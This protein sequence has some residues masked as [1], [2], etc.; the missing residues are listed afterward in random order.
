MGLF[1]RKSKEKYRSVRFAYSAGLPGYVEGEVVS[2]TINTDAGMLVIKPLVC[3]NHPEINLPLSRITEV[4]EITEEEIKEKNKSVLGRAAVG[5]LLG[6]AGAIVGGLSGVGSKKKTENKYFVVIKYTD[7]VDDT[8]IVLEVV[9]AS[10]G[11][12]KFVQELSPKTKSETP[13]GPITL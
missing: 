12:G 9:G 2:A 4:T 1:S 11:S 7:A 3:K 10:L 6:P 13:S 5:A 8:P